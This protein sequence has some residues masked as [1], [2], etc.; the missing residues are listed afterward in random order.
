MKKPICVYPDFV[1]FEENNKFWS[2][3][4]NGLREFSHEVKT[5]INNLI[6]YAEDRFHGID[7]YWFL[8]NT[9]YGEINL[10]GEEDEV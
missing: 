9:L 10:K 8:G 3:D 4:Q 2:L 1:I 5:L 6:S 7:V